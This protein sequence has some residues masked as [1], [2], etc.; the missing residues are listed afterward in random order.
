MNELKSTDSS[1]LVEHFEKGAK[2]DVLKSREGY[3]RASD[4]Q[5]M[6]EMYAITALPADKVKNQWDIFSSSGS[7]PGPDES[8]EAIAATKEENSCT[9]S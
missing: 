1:K 3:F 6:H 9:F 7:V 4:H 8:L 2:F 5:M